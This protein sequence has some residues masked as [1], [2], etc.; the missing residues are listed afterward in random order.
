MELRPLA[1]SRVLTGRSARA[2]TWTEAG[3]RARGRRAHR[4]AEE[5]LVDDGGLRPDSLSSW[6]R[7]RAGGRAR[8]WLPTVARVPT[9]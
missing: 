1:M 6:R 5:E 4:R 2:R 3:R 7:A 8:I 9:G